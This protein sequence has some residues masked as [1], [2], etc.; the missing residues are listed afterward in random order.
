MEVSIKTHRSVCL[1]L[2]HV[3]RKKISTTVGNS[4]SFIRLCVAFIADIM[5]FVAFITG[6]LFNKGLSAEN[7]T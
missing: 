6:N 4:T 7:T 3:C 5:L 2:K 1:G